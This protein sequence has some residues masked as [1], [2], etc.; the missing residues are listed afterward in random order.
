[1]NRTLSSILKTTL[2]S[3]MLAAPMTAFGDEPLLMTTFEANGFTLS[4]AEYWPYHGS[5]E[6]RYPEE[7]LWGFYPQAGVIPPD[8]EDPNPDT[9]TPLAV[10]CAK[11]AWTKL[12]TFLANPP[13]ELQEVVALGT[14]QGFTPKF[15][16][17]TNDYS[18]ANNPY[19][20]TY[21]PSHLWFWKRNPQI[22]GRTPGYWKWESTVGYDGS[23][24]IP[25]DSQIQTYIHQKLVELRG[26]P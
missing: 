23:C 18:R 9:A 25:D 16:L 11:Q 12:H 14:A 7:V 24:S 3:L 6:F 20:F 21:R 15:Y 8:E 1:M 10:D 19:P 4:G 22:E 5:Q 17:W 13:A 26:T 2:C